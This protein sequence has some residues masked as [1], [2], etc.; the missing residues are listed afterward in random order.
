MFAT[1]LEPAAFAK[2]FE[3]RLAFVKRLGGPFITSDPTEVAHAQAAGVQAALLI[4]DEA[5]LDLLAAVKAGRKAN[6]EMIAVRTES[7]GVAQ[8]TRVARASRLASALAAAEGVHRMIIAVDGSLAPLSAAE[9]SELPAESLL[10][11]PIDDPES[12][13]AAAT[14]P[15]DR[16]LVL[17]LLPSPSTTVA[18]EPREVLLWGLRYAASLGGRGGARVGFTERPAPQRS[19]SQWRDRNA[20][21]AEECVAL[22]AD[23]LRLTAANEATLREDLDPRSFSPAAQRLERRNGG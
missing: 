4:R 11:D 15:G 14:L 20:A 17:A 19:S 16:G 2:T 9:W 10:I 1:L 13:R 7:L 3:E 8:D 22:L 23:L 5:G 21:A 12:W 18:A 6:P